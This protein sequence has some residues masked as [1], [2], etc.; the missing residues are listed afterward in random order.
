MAWDHTGSG[1]GPLVLRIAGQ[2]PVSGRGFS[3][4]GFSLDHV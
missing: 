4:R 1:P 3:G 2:M